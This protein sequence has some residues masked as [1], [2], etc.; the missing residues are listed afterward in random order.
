MPMGAVQLIPGVNTQKTLLANQSGVS[1]AQLI[2]YKDQ[3]IQSLGGWVNFINATLPSTVRDLHAWQ[4]LRNDKHLASGATQN[5]SVI[6]AGS[7]VDITPQ[8]L[9]TNPAPNLSI[10]SGQT[11]V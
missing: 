7:A 10:S 3:M 4:G 1:D 5:L 9:T 8:A 11:V 2:R 6:T